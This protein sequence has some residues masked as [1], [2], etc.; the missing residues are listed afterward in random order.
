MELSCLCDLSLARLWDILSI[1]EDEARIQSTPPT[2]PAIQNESFLLTSV[3]CLA[4][5]NEVSQK[6][7][8]IHL[9]LLAR[10]TLILLF[11]HS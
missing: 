1:V 2:Q 7:R 9:R 8:Q 10:P 5:V 3:H 6:S 11:L 4:K